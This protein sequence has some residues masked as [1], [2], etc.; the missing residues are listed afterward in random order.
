MTEAKKKGK[1]VIAIVVGTDEDPQEINDQIERLTAVGAN[2]FTNVND[3]LDYVYNRLPT[4]NT[5]IPDVA[6]D[7]FTKIR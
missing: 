4:V 5:D 6:L 3:A 2:V 1:R 7:A